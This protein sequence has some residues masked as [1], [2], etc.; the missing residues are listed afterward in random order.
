MKFGWLEIYYCDL[1]CFSSHPRC[2]KSKVGVEE[3]T[4]AKD[5]VDI[6][7]SRQM[8]SSK[9]V[10]L[11][12]LAW[13]Q[14]QCSLLSLLSLFWTF[15]TASPPSFSCL[16]SLIVIHANLTI[17][18]PHPSTKCVQ[19]RCQQLVQPELSSL[20]LTIAAANWSIKLMKWVTPLLV[21][22]ASCKWHLPENQKIEFWLRKVAWQRHGPG[23][24]EIQDQCDATKPANLG[25]LSVLAFKRPYGSP[26]LHVPWSHSLRFF[27][28]GTGKKSSQLLPSIFRRLELWCFSQ[29]LK[30][31]AVQES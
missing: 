28:N 27:E 11:P 18:S 12:K 14:C 6:A 2:T 23:V 21:D 31:V 3:S 19:I 30:G 1:I 15:C 29:E 9:N 13:R 7:N 5:L 17:H 16:Q 10:Q 20:I 22:P 8:K 4:H 26:M 25:T 24:E